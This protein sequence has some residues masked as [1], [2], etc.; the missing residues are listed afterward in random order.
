VYINCTNVFH[1]D[2]SRHIR[3]CNVVFSNS[4][5]L[6]P[7]TFNSYMFVCIY[8]FGSPGVELR[9]SCLLVRHC[10][11]GATLTTLF[12]VEYF[13]N[14]VSRTVCLG[15]LRTLILLIYAS[16]VAR[17]TGVSHHICFHLIEIL[18]ANTHLSLHAVYSISISFLSA[19]IRVLNLLCGNAMSGP[20]A[21]SAP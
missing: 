10:T 15:W 5:C 21:S 3:A 7:F 17:I 16:W 4:P 6:H 13:W 8:F 9:A 14:R 11:F 2:I 12:S 19:L 20:D 18:V 1:C